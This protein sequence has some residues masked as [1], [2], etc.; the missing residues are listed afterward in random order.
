MESSGL[1]AGWDGPLRRAAG[2][3]ATMSSPALTTPVSSPPAPDAGY[4]P[5]LSLYTRI[6]VVLTFILLGAGVLTA[7]K[8]AGLSIPDWPL[9]FHRLV[10]PFVGNIRFEYTHRVLAGCVSLMTV[11][12]VIWLWRV[13]RRRWLRWLGV[14]ALLGV[15]LQAILGGLTV[16]DFQ[17]PWL[18]AFH[19]SV[20]QLFFVT[21]VAIAIFTGRP[22]RTAVRLR[23]DA[24]PG[25]YTLCVVTTAVI[26][27]Q[28]ILGAAYR[29]DALPLW[30]H[31]VGAAV[32]TAL[33]LWTAGVALQRH[34]E[35]ARIRRAA[36]GLLVVLGLQIAFGLN[37]YL[38]REKTIHAPQPPEAR[39]GAAV[40]HLLCGA[41]LL[42]TALLLTLRARQY[43]SAPKAAERLA[44]PVEL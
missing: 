40:I 1:T 2:R 15:I 24:T 5:A 17:P 22:W 43:L 38:I 21:T 36:R 26:Y 18:T 32:V 6:W 35:I 20:A 25:L 10:P 16:L 19:A 37:V 23:P 13:E 9:A 7:A 39:V 14:A 4:S 42:A 28:I 30:P 29:H 41:L 12:L 8:G 44:A 3:R 11:G 31:L 33:V 34:K 27:G